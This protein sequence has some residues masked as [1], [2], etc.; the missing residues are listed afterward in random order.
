[1][2][3]QHSARVLVS[4]FMLLWR[5]LKK[6]FAIRY[7]GSLIGVGWALLLPILT[8]GIYAVVYVYIFRFRPA[9]MAPAQYA[10]FMFS[11]LVPCLMASE[12]VASGVSSFI[13]NK[14]LLN[15]TVFPID[16]A[17]VKSVLLSQ[18]TAV[19]GF[20]IIIVAAAAG[21]MLHETMLLLPVL[22]LLLLVFLIGVNWT[23]SVVCIVFRDLQYL[24]HPVLMVV[25]LASP[26]AYTIEMVPTA[27]RLLIYLNPLAYFVIAFQKT[28]ILGQFPGL[29]EWLPVIALALGSFIAGGF[30][31][32]GCKRAL[33]DYV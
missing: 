17:P 11:G 19:G 10:L 14:S 30:V 24:I 6:E 16:L 21:K 3:T 22:W 25:L 26:I 9:G 1:M 29:F 13:A 8:L 2:T 7:A 5:V 12:S 33:T 4:H 18:G 27:W 23:L 20:A 28:M 15:N 32:A 31:F